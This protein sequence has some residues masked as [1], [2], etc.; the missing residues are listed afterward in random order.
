MEIRVTPEMLSAV[1]RKLGEKGGASK[2][3]AKADAARRNGAKNKPKK[4]K[5]K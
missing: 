2:S 5:K 1:M 3:K 4:A